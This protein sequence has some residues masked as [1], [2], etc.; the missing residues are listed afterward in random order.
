MGRKSTVYDVYLNAIK[1]KEHNF[2]MDM[3]KSEKYT[4]FVKSM[5]D[6]AK[7][8]EDGITTRFDRD[9]S[10]D[11]IREKWM[12]IKHI[13]KSFKHQ[14]EYKISLYNDW[15]YDVSVI[16]PEVK[17]SSNP[18]NFYVLWGEHNK[19][20]KQN[21]IKFIICLLSFVGMWALFFADVAHK[22]EPDFVTLILTCAILPITF[23]SLGYGY[24]FGKELYY[25]YFGW[26]LILRGIEKAGF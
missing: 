25:H 17:Q 12:F 20:T 6:A 13:I 2:Y 8:G 26:Y 14:F 11:K 24:R 5:V 21:I 10:S 15:S 22:P 19:H 16:R 7:E 1:E 4:D 18:E 23:C 9:D 3:L